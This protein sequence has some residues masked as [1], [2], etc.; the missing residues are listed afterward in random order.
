MEKNVYSAWK[1]HHEV[2]QT[3]QGKR[4]KNVGA[5]SAAQRHDHEGM[6]T[7]HGNSIMR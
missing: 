2:I 6:R 4:M 3:V 7:V 5:N 1:V